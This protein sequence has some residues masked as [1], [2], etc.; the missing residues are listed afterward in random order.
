MQKYFDITIPIK[1]KMM[2]YE[3]DPEVELTPH[4]SIKNGD[5]FNLL[6]IKMGSHTGTHMDA[7]CHFFQNGRTVEDIPVD[8]L[9]GT[10]RVVLIRNERVITRKA[11]QNIDLTGV[12]RVLF[13]T[14][15]SYLRD[16]YHKFRTDYVYIDVE[17]ASYLAS[18]GIKVIGI[19]S[20][21]IEEYG[22]SSNLCHKI[23]LGAGIVILEMLDLKD[24]QPGDYELICL[25]LKIQQGDGAP[26]RAVLRSLQ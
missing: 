21:S 4:C 11:L 20:I 26:V 10:A 9:I 16:R 25:P 12:E 23:L 6:H 2:V 5:A 24:I 8:T 18:M 1:N 19:D 14:D 3:G 7:P 22:N 13:K 17:C 15:H